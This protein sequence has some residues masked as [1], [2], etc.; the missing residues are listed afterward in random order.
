MTHHATRRR[1]LVAAATLPILM[2]LPARAATR[3]DV[4]MLNRDPDQPGAVMVYKPRLLEVAP[5][6]SVRFLATAKGHNAQSIEGM[7]PDGAESWRGRIN[8]EIEVTL[9]L[10]GVYGY[11]CLPHYAVGM[12]GLIVVRGDGPAPNLDTARA[13]EHPGRAGTA[14]EEIFAAA[15]AEGLLA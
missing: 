13:V 11:K 1:L 10:P 8:E 15:E 14:F 5:G 9:E 7:I 4:K 6:D 3:H 12:V 2:H